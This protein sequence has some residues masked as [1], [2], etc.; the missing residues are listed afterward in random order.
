MLLIDHLNPLANKNRS[1]PAFREWESKRT[2]RI[3]EGLK[4]GSIR[5]WDTFFY[6]DEHFAE[7]NRKRPIEDNLKTFTLLREL[8]DLRFRS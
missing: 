5:L 1:S 2:Q 6:T 7:W 3:M 8:K 4:K